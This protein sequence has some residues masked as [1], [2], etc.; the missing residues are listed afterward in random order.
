MVLAL[1]LS[2]VVGCS[3]V[4]TDIHETGVDKDGNE[5]DKH[6]RVKAATVFDSKSELAKL[7]TTATDKTQSVSISG[8]S[9]ESSTSNAVNMAE[10]FASGA[11]QGA[12]KSVKPVPV[13]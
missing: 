2:F 8:L 10:A 3:T 12:M 1:G 7:H 4:T 11:V 9:Q 5:F 13:Q 6:T